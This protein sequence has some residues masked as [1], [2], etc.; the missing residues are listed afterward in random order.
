MQKVLFVTNMPAP[1]R[2]DLFYYLQTHV[3]Q[4]EF[5]VMYCAGKEDNR[6][7]DV[8]KK[9]ILNSCFAKCAVIAIRRKYDTK[10]IYIPKQIWRDLNNINPD[11]VIGGEYSPITII[12]LLWCRLHKRK[13]ISFT[14]GSLYSERNIN[15]IQKLNR[16][17]ITQCCD[18]AVASSTKAKEKLLAW[19]MPPQKIFMSL[20]TVDIDK[21]T[22]AVHEPEAGRLLYVGS[23]IE[24]KGLDLLIEALRYVKSDFSLHIVGNGSEQEIN[25]LK[26]KATNANVIDS[27]HFCG[28]KQGN[29][30]VEEYRKAQVF[31][32]PTRED[33]FGLVLLEAMC[34]KVPIVTS[35]YADG[36][37]DVVKDGENGFIID[38]YD[39]RQFGNAIDRAINDRNL[40]E[41][42][43]VQN[44]E[45]FSFQNVV[46]GYIDALSYTL[47]GKK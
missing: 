1:Y 17:I 25:A 47:K 4:Y 36:A 29:D 28:F 43:S 14:D 32:L 16:R 19:G 12:T 41:N 23:M 8:D 11:V 38:P 33:C 44:V 5:H 2:V 10:Y 34:A 3:K 21:L 46:S 35:K 30:L 42:A 18:A 20:L 26:T 45:K 9:K 27:I 37:Y 24:R 13:Y 31:V 22:V 39:A 40:A 15:I 6:C 7:W